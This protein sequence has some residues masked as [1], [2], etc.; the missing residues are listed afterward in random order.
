MYLRTSYCTLIETYGQSW[1]FASRRACVTS[2]CILMEV[3][4]DATKGA[5]EKS[6]KQGKIR[7]EVIVLLYGVRDFEIFP[8]LMFTYFSTYKGSDFWSP[9]K[10]MMMDPTFL[11][12]L[13]QVNIYEVAPMKIK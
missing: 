6:Q 10:R 3:S 8:L 1:T 13:I 5:S 11:E 12:K 7:L 9:G 4:P 2:L